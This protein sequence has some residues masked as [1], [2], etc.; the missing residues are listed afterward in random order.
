MVKKVALFALMALLLAALSPV[1]AAQEEVPIPI[2]FDGRTFYVDEPGQVGRLHFGWVA[3]NKGL[4]QAYINASYIEV[5][6]DGELLLAPDQAHDLWEPIVPFLPSMEC[7][8]QRSQ[9]HAAPWHYVLAG[10]G[11]GEYELRSIIALTH[12][13]A[14]GCDVDGDGKPD[15]LTPFHRETVNTIIVQ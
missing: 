4:T 11:P 14:D 9:S 10:L 5:Y 13:V 1:S 7:C 8:I 12:P 3:C 15:L 2:F 6:L